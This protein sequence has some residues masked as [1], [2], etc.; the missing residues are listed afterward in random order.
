MRTLLDMNGYLL[1]A[2]TDIGGYNE[3]HRRQTHHVR[4]PFR[5]VSFWFN[6]NAN[7]NP[8]LS[9]QLRSISHGTIYFDMHF[10]FNWINYCK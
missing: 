5:I 9:A 7:A 10:A 6:E 8:K 3:I 1:V 4:Y 2:H